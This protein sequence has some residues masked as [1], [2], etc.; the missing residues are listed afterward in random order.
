M[1]AV[2]RA[3]RPW[4]SGSR[5]TG[6]KGRPPRPSPPSGLQPADRGAPRAAGDLQGWLGLGIL[7]SYCLQPVASHP[8][9]GAESAG[10][11]GATRWEAGSRTAE[12]LSVFPAPSSPWCPQAGRT[13]RP[14][15]LP[16][17]RSPQGRSPVPRPLCSWESWRP[18]GGRPCQV[19]FLAP[20]LP[21]TFKPT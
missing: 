19:P 5:R 7:V 11:A 20:T 4:G 12:S 13:C 15:L 3:R 6:G 21:A 14:C 2:R 16:S 18:L 1:P 8:E 17:G 9:R 10:V